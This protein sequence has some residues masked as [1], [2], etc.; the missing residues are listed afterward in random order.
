MSS[1]CV[2][3]DH[4][5]RVLWLI[6]EAPVLERNKKIDFLKHEQEEMTFRLR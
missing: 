2:P 6:K 5:S 3:L 1:R 4:S